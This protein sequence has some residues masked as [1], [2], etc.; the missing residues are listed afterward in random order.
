[1]ITLKT[2][3][4]NKD[5]S[6][7]IGGNG[8][9]IMIGER[10]NPTGKKKLADALRK[11]DMDAV[12]AE[13]KAQIA[14]GAQILD[15]NVVTEDVNEMDILPRAIAAILEVADIP[16]C[17]DVNNPNALKK[18][19]DLYPGKAL[20]NSVSAEKRSLEEV[21][22]LVKEY[23]AAVIGL[24][25]DD[26]GIPKTAEKRLEIACRIIDAAKAIGI[27]KEDIIIDS[28][29]LALGSDDQAAAV[30]LDSVRMINE[31]LGVNQTLGASNV[32]FGLPNR[33]EVNKAFLPLAISAGV[34]CP[35]VNPLHVGA[36][37]MAT[38]L[39]LGRD[40]FSMRYIT[41]YRNRN[42]S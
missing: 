38:D 20:V 31:A 12:K 2:I 3:V 1:M 21:L 26:D 22:P 40:R 10:I 19:L 27:P 4:S 42:S 39:I 36:T 25:L 13:A 15:V 16:L 23:N 37:I 28:L 7:T 14:A 18:A 9:T 30:T 11:G 17:I 8:P 34:T 33:I 24:A 41:D 32:S 35:T 6:V 5:T 29:S